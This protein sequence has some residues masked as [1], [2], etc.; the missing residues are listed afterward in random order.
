MLVVY[1]LEHIFRIYHVLTTRS[2]PGDEI[3][4]VNC[5]TTPSYTC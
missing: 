2:S 1:S 4:N 3:A 5:F